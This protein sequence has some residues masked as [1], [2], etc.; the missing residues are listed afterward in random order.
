MD[1]PANHLRARHIEE[2]TRLSADDILNAF[3]LGSVRRGRRA[4][5]ALC[6]PAARRLA[7]D[8]ARYDEEVGVGGLGAGARLVL[9][10]YVQQ[11]EVAGQ[12]GIPLTGPL[13]IA[14]NHP[15][16]TD[17]VALFASLPRPDLRILAAERPFL[18][19]L[20]NTCQRLIFAPEEPRQRLTALRAIIAHFRS[21]G[22]V[23][24]FPGGAIEPDPA[25]LPGAV[26]ALGQWSESVG[27]LVRL[28]PEIQVVPAVV[29]GV[30]SERAQRHPFT[31]LRRHQRDR[32]WLGAI[33]Q[34]LVPTYHQV[35]VR[36]AYGPPMAA[37][38]LLGHDRAA[39]RITAR[40]AAEARRLIEAPSARWQPLLSVDAS[41]AARACSELWV[42]G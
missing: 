19:A 20:P 40:V 37:A 11:V 7:H 33:L 17:T 13:L 31:R 28:A 30:L 16:L 24:T 5:R 32:E 34:L 23:L 35:R 42:S 15:G 39:T 41:P 18:R 2:L 26:T 1:E 3:G 21:G 4:W 12:D 25:V 38:E 22:A 9:P 27:A 10:R 6:R 8:V 14:A 36:V 29:S